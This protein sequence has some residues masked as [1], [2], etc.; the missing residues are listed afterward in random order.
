MIEFFSNTGIT[1]PVALL[2]EINERLRR[3]LDATGKMYKNN[4]PSVKRLQ[5]ILRQ[6]TI[7]QMLQNEHV[8]AVAGAPGAGKSTLMRLIYDLNQPDTAFISGRTGRGERLP[9]WIREMENI[10]KPS[11][12]VYVYRWSD[13]PNRQIEAIPIGSAEDFAQVA[14]DPQTDDNCVNIMLELQ[15]PCKMFESGNCGFLLLPGFENYHIADNRDN[16]WNQL[17]RFSLI[18]ASRFMLVVDNVA[19]YQ[20]LLA[21]E[22]FQEWFGNSHP[23]F[24]L[25]R[26]ENEPDGGQRKKDALREKLGLSEKEADRIVCTGL[27]DIG[28]WSENMRNSLKKYN[29]RDLSAET[30]QLIQLGRLLDK[31]L[32]DL[33]SEIK[34]DAEHAFHSE[35]SPMDNALREF[36]ETYEQAARKEEGRFMR[37]LEEALNRGA[38]EFI[39]TAEKEYGSSSFWEKFG[40]FA[41]RKGRP[42]PEVVRRVES[43]VRTAWNEHMIGV[44][45]RFYQAQLGEVDDFHKLSNGYIDPAQLSDEQKKTIKQLLRQL[46]KLSGYA[47]MQQPQRA[48]FLSEK[49]PQ[50]QAE[51]S[52]EESLLGLAARASMAFVPAEAAAGVAAAALVANHLIQAIR[53][54]EI[55]NKKR[56]VADT[57]R[58]LFDRTLASSREDYARLADE[59]QDKIQHQLADHLGVETAK[60]EF[61]NIQLRINHLLE[62]IKAVREIVNKRT[63]YGMTT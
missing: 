39:T 25:P 61:L 21:H 58:I 43:S 18:A 47:L 59:L 22:Q 42:S 33:L 50:L 3:L 31:E 57:T 46:P 34:L 7:L 16:Q 29:D 49:I 44:T 56:V 53:E 13:E 37:R 36:M 1:D 32:Y 11:A 35:H 8:V 17:I 55:H 24:V 12:C 14:H 48:G 6:T 41:I 54:S 27:K 40:N 19:S 51:A 2:G 10:S 5:N 60:N 15:V 26:S 20:E 45:D 62:S 30:I 4:H 9:I 28:A 38:D 23:L 63:A 52:S